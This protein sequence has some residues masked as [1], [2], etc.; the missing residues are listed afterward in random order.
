MC[1]I[2]TA[3]E[4]LVD[5]FIVSAKRERYKAMMA[6]GKR[7]RSFL[8]VLNHC[9]DIDPRYATAIA[10]NADVVALLS[11]R[12][13][14]KTCHVISEVSELDGKEMTLR[15]AVDAAEA[16]MFGT[17]VGCIPGRLAYFYDESGSRRLLLER[18]VSQKR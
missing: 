1:S 17:L 7:R 16:H 4:A 10:S 11:S 18:A 6:N 2:Q 8:D 9:A 5:A 13:A 14:P 15:D 12:G 3:E